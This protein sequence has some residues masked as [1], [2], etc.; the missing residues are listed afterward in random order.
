MLVPNNPDNKGNKGFVKF[1]KFKVVIPNTPDV[2]N[3]ISAHIL[4]FLSFRIKKAEEVIRINAIHFF[5]VAYIVIIIIE[6][7]GAK[8]IAKINAKKLPIKVNITAS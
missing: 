8:I 2:K 7:I 5:K 6:I 3:I 4:D 1:A